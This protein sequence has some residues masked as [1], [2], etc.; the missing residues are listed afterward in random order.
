MIKKFF[1]YLPS[2]IFCG[3]ILTFMILWIALPKESFSQ[4]E[5]RELEKFPEVNFDTVFSGEFQSKLDTYMS[6]H[7]PARSFFI[8]LNADYALL[9]GRNG[10]N[11]IVLNKEGRYTDA[12]CV[13]LGSDGYL[14]AKPSRGTK[15]MENASYIKEYAEDSDIPVYMTV[16]PSSGS[17]NTEKLPYNHPEYKDFELIGEV[18]NAVEKEVEFVDLR[19]TF[20]SLS[21][22]KQLYYK[23]DHHWTSAGAYECYKLLGEK[24]GFEPVSEKNFSKE[25]INGFYGTSYARAALWFVEPDIL[26]LWHNKNQT[27][28]SV[29]VQIING[30][31]VDKENNDYFFRDKLDLNDKYEVFL[32]GVY[33]YERIVNNDVKDGTLVVV[34]DSYGHTIVPFLSQ[35]YHE[36]IMIDLRYFKQPVS[37]V[38]AE[39]D[40]DAVLVLYSLDNLSTDP[41]VNFLE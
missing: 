22:K 18:K 35:N 25:R 31:K 38:A 4:Q 29:S 20:K 26:E 17:V 23:T 27:E 15:L 28:D 21:D 2:F 37:D 39:V 19:D 12:D 36:I 11:G 30:G 14:F 5:K 24:M 9:S 16:V 32:D 34:K 41:Y 10:Y 7:T 33:G 40:A 13:A 8:G 6:D 1:K 3:F